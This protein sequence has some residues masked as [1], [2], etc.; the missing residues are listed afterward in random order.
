MHFLINNNLVVEE[1]GGIRPPA[2]ANSNYSRLELLSKILSPS[3]ERMFIT[4][5]LIVEGN[6]NLDSISHEAKKIA[7]KVSRLYG[8]NSPEFSDG[9]V[10]ESFVQELKSRKA[11]DISESGLIVSNPNIREIVRLAQGVVS[12]EIKQAINHAA[13]PI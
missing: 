6:Q 4:L 10:F 12:A 3:V 9:S 7:H 2:R 11:I 8:I 1:D 13:S 5:N